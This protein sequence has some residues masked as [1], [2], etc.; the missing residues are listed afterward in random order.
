MTT[1]VVLMFPAG[2]A[3]GDTQ[4]ATVPIIND[5]VLEM[6]GE[7]FF[8]DITSTDAMVAPGFDRATI[9]FIESNDGGK[10]SF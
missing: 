1:T 3:T 2:A 5:N 9:T 7:N 8:A 10:R 4:C 6:T